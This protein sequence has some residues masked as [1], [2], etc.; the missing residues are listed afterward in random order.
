MTEADLALKF[1]EFFEDYDIYK[2]V[3]TH[4]GRCDF[5]AISH[6]IYIS[7]EVKK[8]FSTQVIYQAYRNFT[9]SHYAYVAVP[10]PVDGY[11]ALQLCKLLGIGVLFYQNKYS[12][13]GADG[14]KIVKIVEQAAYR[15]KISKPQLLETMKHAVA[16]AQ[17]NSQSNFKV[18]INLIEMWCQRKGGSM[19]LKELFEKDAYHYESPKHAKQAIVRYVRHGILKQFKIENGVIT[20]VEQAQ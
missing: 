19:L 10:K 16:G 6:S 3:P 12:N 9:Q 11:P 1:I 17:H 18:T 4:Y 5:F 13:D 20:L 14:K 15:R 2:E 8:Q 7:V